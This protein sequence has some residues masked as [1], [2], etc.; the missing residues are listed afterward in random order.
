MFKCLLKCE[1]CQLLCFLPSYRYYQSFSLSENHINSILKLML[2]RLFV[3]HKFILI[4]FLCFISFAFL[5]CRNYRYLRL[6]I[7]DN[8]VIFFLGKIKSFE[9]TSRFKI[10][11]MTSLQSDRTKISN[12]LQASSQ[13]DDSAIWMSKLDAYDSNILKLM[14]ERNILLSL[15]S[16]VAID[17]DSGKIAVDKYPVKQVD[18]FQ[19]NRG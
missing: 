5:S 7:E 17:R 11:L 15:K 9:E 2:G 16:S 13:G 19:C 3:V 4:L 14:E 18:G 1:A 12:I 8:K 10:K 6:L